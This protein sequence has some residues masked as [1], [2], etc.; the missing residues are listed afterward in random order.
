MPKKA[1]AAAVG[2]APKTEI[3]RKSITKLR[4]DFKKKI[5]PFI[6]SAGDTEDPIPPL[7]NEMVA[8]LKAVHL[9]ISTCVGKKIDLDVDSCSGTLETLAYNLDKC[10]DADPTS[11][12]ECITD[13]FDFQLELG[14]GKVQ[15]FSFSFHRPLLWV[16]REMLLAMFALD[17]P[18]DAI[19]AAVRRALLAP[20][21]YCT[22]TEWREKPRHT[23]DLLLRG[24][25]SKDWD[26]NDHLADNDTVPQKQLGRLIKLCEKRGDDFKYDR[27]D[28]YEFNNDEK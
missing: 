25:C 16:W 20:S 21:L 23:L 17:Q 13:G 7:V 8:A 3:V 27:Y 14:G 2:D 22:N 1:A 18:E 10:T 26:G 12:N 15:Q 24:G 9:H 6:K 11:T 19:V 28:T 5:Y 4:R